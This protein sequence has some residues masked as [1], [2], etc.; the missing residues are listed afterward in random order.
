[1]PIIREKL[2][3]LSLITLVR[4]IS[5]RSLVVL[6]LSTPLLPFVNVNNVNALELT[7]VQSTALLV[8]YWRDVETKRKHQES[9]SST[10]TSTRASLV[11]DP[12]ATVLVDTL[13][14]KESRDAY[15]ASPIRDVGIDCLALRTRLID[16]WLMRQLSIPSSNED[17]VNKRG[18][19][20]K[21]RQIVN[22]GAGMDGRPYRLDFEQISTR[23]FE[24]D[25]DPTLLEIKKKVLE[26]AGFQQSCPTFSVGAN[27]EDVQS[28][29]EALQKMDDFD[30]NADTDWIAEG[31]LEYMDPTLHHPPLLQMAYD[32]CGPS[33]RM[34]MQVLEPPFGELFKSKLGADT[35]P[36]KRLVCAKDIVAVAKDIGWSSATILTGDDLSQKY[37]KRKIVDLPGYT[38]VCLEKN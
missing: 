4:V 33:S 16:D 9:S 17:E 18:L 3:L 38:M 24:I 31:L 10:L 19:A 26:D 21:P 20:S 6:S 36:W 14:S 13:L 29:I 8:A 30:S 11:S 5:L 32:L 1:M 35:L 34:I 28:T 27:L 37:D 12:T 7:P 22:L 23:I 2:W 15:A 25:S